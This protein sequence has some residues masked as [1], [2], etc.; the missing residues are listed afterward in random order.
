MRSMAQVLVQTQILLYLLCVV[1][2]SFLK[3]GSTLACDNIYEKANVKKGTHSTRVGFFNT[4]LS[5]FP[6]TQ[7]AH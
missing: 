3:V 1:N 6:N 5:K 2:T 7:Q 4:F